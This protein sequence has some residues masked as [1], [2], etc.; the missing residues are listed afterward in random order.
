VDRRAFLER[1]GLTF[2][3]AA[4]A[5]LS[6]ASAD[7]QSAQQ[8]A[9][10]TDWTSVRGLFSLDPAF[11]HFGGLYLASH[12]APVQQAIDTHRRGLDSNPVD[13]LH[14]QAPG[15][16]AAVLRAAAGYV[17][18]SPTDVALT[19][20]TTMGLGLLYNGVAIRADQEVLT[21]QHDFYATHE[22]LRLAAS[23]TGATVRQIALYQDFSSVSADELVATIAQAL[24]ERTRVLAVTWVHSSTG[25]KLPLRRIADVVSAVN[26][27][28][29]RSER[30]LFCV[31]G[32][33]G[34]GV[35]DVAVADLGV[36]F[37]VSG[38]H[39]WLFGPRGTGLVWGRGA[40]AWAAVTPTIP[41]FGD[42]RA[43][44]SLNTPGGFHS[45][46]HRWALSAA[47]DLHQQIGRAAVASRIHALN[48]TLKAGLAG[49]SKVRVITPLDED[50][51]AGLVCFEVAG[52]GP[53]EVVDRLHARGIIA[54]MT[55]Y[56]TA[57]AR[58]AA[59]IFNTEEEV[60]AAV[61]EVAAL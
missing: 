36:D 11:V 9:Q 5:Q 42:G 23:R 21:T 59:G 10:A 57:Y 44:G 13:Y 51:S 53:Q 7:V 20:S 32:V 34:F 1:T 26:A 49:L 58:L 41:T 38:C 47:F 37:F 4:L 30:V 43:Y 22:A 54:T 33:H 35:E 16:E 31:D 2:A 3:A 50:L 17:G 14:A 6:S 27:Q 19:D 28:R 60:D 45:F 48:G 52:L 46:E 25:L 56:A 8:Q 61:R 24:T 55:P 39:K 29:E 40:D 12:P 18:G 15:L